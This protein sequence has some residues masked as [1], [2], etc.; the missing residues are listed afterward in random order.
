MLK[1]INK[2]DKFNIMFRHQYDLSSM[3]I[4]YFTEIEDIIWVIWDEIGIK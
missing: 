4:L 2:H 1:K 3:E